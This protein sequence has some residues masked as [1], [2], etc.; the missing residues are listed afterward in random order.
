M[1][2]QMELVT[3]RTNVN[4]NKGQGQTLV[5]RG[6]EFAVSVSSF[7]SYSIFFGKPDSCVFQ[8][9]RLAGRQFQRT[10]PTFGLDQP[11]HHNGF[12]DC[13]CVNVR[14]TFVGFV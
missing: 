7:L 13:H 8:F 4:P 1:L 10:C 12:A 3:P 6:M 11:L 5:P 9:T 2:E 14:W